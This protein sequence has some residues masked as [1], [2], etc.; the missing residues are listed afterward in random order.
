[1]GP[2]GILCTLVG[3]LLGVLFFAVAIFQIACKWCGLER[4]GIFAAAG[5]VIVSWFVWAV[6]EGV[7]L[8]VLEEIY[9]AAGLPPWEARIVGFFVGL[10]FHLAVTT[11]LHVGLMRV[12]V[13]KAIEVWFVQN[14]I[15]FS[16]V[17]LVVG[18]V[19]VA[20]LAR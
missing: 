7:M 15:V 17:L 13:G 6:F 20:L 2:L 18:L 8:A 4:P 5:I 14:V 16:I 11:A 10:P 9:N 1:M 12:K 19:M 3:F